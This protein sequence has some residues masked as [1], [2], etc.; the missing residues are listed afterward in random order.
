FVAGAPLDDPRV[1]VV[2]VIEDPE[3][4]LGYYGGAVAGPIVRDVIDET[5]TYLGVAP[6][7][8]PED[9]LAGAVALG[10]H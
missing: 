5:L 9:G 2:C 7:V 4:A 3:P 10:D 8:R 6:D 1:V